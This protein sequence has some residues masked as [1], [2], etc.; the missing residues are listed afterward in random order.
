MEDKKL[1]EARRFRQLAGITEGDS[2]K[3]ISNEKFIDNNT[4]LESIAKK[5]SIL[6][7]E[8]KKEILTESVVTTEAKTEF[9]IHEFEPKKTESK[10]DDKTLY[11]LNESTDSEGYIDLDF[12]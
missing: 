7:E 10:E 5:T 8:V 3:Y 1:A 12:I 4:L 2:K 6:T 11:T 9:D